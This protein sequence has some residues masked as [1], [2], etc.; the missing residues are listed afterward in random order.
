MIKYYRVE[1][2][3]QGAPNFATA[4]EVTVPQWIPFTCEADNDGGQDFCEFT[5]ELPEDGERILVCINIPGHEA[6]QMDEWYDDGGDC[7]LDSGYT[8]VTEAVAWMPLP[9]PFT[10]DES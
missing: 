1:L 7:G 8:P 6:V 10:E 5:C 3:S 4:E 9:S 2:N